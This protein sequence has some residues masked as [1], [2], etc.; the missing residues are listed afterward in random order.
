MADLLR[1][2][3]D[4]AHQTR[5]TVVGEGV[6]TPEEWW[7]V[8]EAGCDLAQGFHLYR[9]MRADDVGLLF[10]RGAEAY[11]AADEGAGSGAGG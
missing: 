7:G 4:H 9:P 10:T 8:A 1:A 5:M 6:E 11:R 3:V 2:L